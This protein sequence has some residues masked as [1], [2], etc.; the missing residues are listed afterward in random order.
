ML[1]LHR[2]P[3]YNLFTLKEKLIPIE[4]DALL[5]EEGSILFFKPLIIIVS[6]SVKDLLCLL[7]HAWSCVKG[8]GSMA[9]AFRQHQ[10]PQACR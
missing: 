5:C 7:Y 9:M 2:Y 1:P 3:E 8:K 10:I 6:L 4:I